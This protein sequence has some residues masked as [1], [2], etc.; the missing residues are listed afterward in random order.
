MGS[1]IGQHCLIFSISLC[2]YQSP[3][4]IMCF[5]TLILNYQL[6]LRKKRWKGET[7]SIKIL[8][9]LS[10]TILLTN[11]LIPCN[12]LQRAPG[13]ELPSTVSEPPTS[14]HFPTWLQDLVSRTFLRHKTCTPLLNSLLFQNSVPEVIFFFNLSLIFFSKKLSF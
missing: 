3:I 12:H 10:W 7:D 2:L 1:S 11:K 13:S 5:S 4:K 8:L 6:L 14:W 9:N